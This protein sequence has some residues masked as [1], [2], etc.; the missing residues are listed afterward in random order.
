MDAGTN[1]E[2]SAETRSFSHLPPDVLSSIAD[3]LPVID[4][5]GFR[6]TCNDF[7]SASSAA[8][9]E[10]E[11]SRTPW[12]LLHKTDSSECV[13]YNEEESKTYHRDIPDLKGAICLAS[14]QG[15]LLL[16][17]DESMFFFCPISLAK[18]ILPEFPHKQIDG[19]VAAFSDV[20]TSSQCIVSVINRIDEKGVEVNMISKGQSVWTPHKIPRC[21][22]L[23]SCIA[24]AT[25]DRN[26]R[27]FYY[28]DDGK[29][30]LAFSLN[31]KRW[32]PYTIVKGTVSKDIKTMPYCYQK[33]A[34]RNTIEDTRDLFNIEDDE[35]VSV[36][37]L[38][39]DTDNCH[40]HLYLNEVVDDSP[41]KTRVRRAVWIQPRF[42]EADTNQLRW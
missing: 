20:P 28:M 3:R 16:F 15:W 25:F 8:S 36:C 21:N 4:L 38:S 24:A 39:Y 33:H 9:A 26:S 12:L 34:F 6:G 35:Y 10:I 41:T 2:V 11:S 23:T 1:N 31:D 40:R 32:T 13:I 5:L 29:T 17:K 19:H 27:T 37:G 30:M 18:I 7:R 42:F 22:S 14:Y